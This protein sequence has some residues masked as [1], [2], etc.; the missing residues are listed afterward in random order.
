[1]LLFDIPQYLQTQSCIFLLG[2][3]NLHILF[4]L[5]FWVYRL[6]VAAAYLKDVKLFRSYVE[7]KIHKMNAC[8][9]SPQYA[10]N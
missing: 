9:G 6:K 2:K 1:M 4:I 3:V 10:F 5:E 8:Y 7:T